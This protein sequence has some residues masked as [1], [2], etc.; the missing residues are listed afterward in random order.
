MYLLSVTEKIICSFAYDHKRVFLKKIEF[1]L[2]YCKALVRK[3]LNLFFH[4][5]TYF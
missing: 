5:K 4:I 1:H 3:K 2:C